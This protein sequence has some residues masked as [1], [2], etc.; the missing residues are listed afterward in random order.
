L[1][2]LQELAKDR[3]M[4]EMREQREEK[5]NEPATVKQ[6]S[7]MDNLGIKYLENINKCDASMLIDRK[8]GRNGQ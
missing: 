1:T 6:K 2:L 8:L 4:E 5:N 7:F 3:R